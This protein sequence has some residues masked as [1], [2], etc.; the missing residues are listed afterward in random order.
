M[1]GLKPWNYPIPS[2]SAIST[3]EP[4]TGQITEPQ[5]WQTSGVA[6]ALTQ[7]GQ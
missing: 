4:Q 7:R 3:G 6:T 1:S 5:D 2:S